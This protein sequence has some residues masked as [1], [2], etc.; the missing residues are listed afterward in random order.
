[1]TILPFAV[2]ATS[3]ENCCCSSKKTGEPSGAYKKV[4]SLVF[5]N[6]AASVAALLTIGALALKGRAWN[7]SPSMGKLF[8]GVGSGILTAWIALVATSILCKPKLERS[9]YGDS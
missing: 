3:A 6:D 7:L 1:M 9:A 2:I 8:L 4:V 5:L